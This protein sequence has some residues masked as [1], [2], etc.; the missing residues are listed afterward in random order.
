MDRLGEQYRRRDLLELT[1]VFTKYDKAEQVSDLQGV[2]QP[3][4]DGSAGAAPPAGLQVEPVVGHRD[5]A[6]VRCSS[7]PL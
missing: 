3:Q 4:G 2:Y 6:A 5:R 1:A 7:Y